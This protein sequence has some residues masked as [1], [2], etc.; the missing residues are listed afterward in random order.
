M[1]LRAS[2]YS[3][4]RMFRCIPFVKAKND[5]ARRDNLNESNKSGRITSLSKNFLKVKGSLFVFSGSNCDRGASA[6]STTLVWWG[7]ASS[8]GIDMGVSMPLSLR[9]MRKL[10]AY[11]AHDHRNGIDV[12]TN[13]NL[14]QAAC[15]SWAL[16]GTYLGVGS[17][18]S[19]NSIIDAIVNV[20]IIQEPP[21]PTGI[22][23]VRAQ[24][25][26]SDGDFTALAANFGN[27]QNG[28]AAAQTAFKTGILRILA[29]ANGLTPNANVAGAYTLHMKT[30]NWWSWDHFGLGVLINGNRMFIQ[31]VTGVPVAIS[32]DRMW[33]ES[34][35]ETVIGINDLLGTHV[36]FID[37]IQRAP[38]GQAQCVV[39]NQTHGII[40][41][42]FNLWH[43]CRVC[44]SVYCPTHV[45]TLGGVVP[46]KTSRSCSQLAC[47]GRTQ[48]EPW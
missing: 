41:S 4:Q 42:V 30:G 46:G 12:Q 34:M 2:S 6:T 22:N 31:T 9:T 37:G 24:Y 21:A 16:T 47:P 40:P 39:C 35:P 7:F 19:A 43:S 14:T 33:D 29:R 11:H 15:W 20:D 26:G 8:S 23:D 38:V 28:S 32:C 25:P 5:R 45:A 17:P 10:A 13:Q 36:N 3:R 1:R 48:A 27:A 18:F 44:G